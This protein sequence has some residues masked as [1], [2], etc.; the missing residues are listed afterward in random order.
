MFCTGQQCMMRLLFWLRRWSHIK[1]AGFYS[2]SARNLAD[3]PS[4]LRDF[5]FAQS[6]LGTARERYWLWHSSPFPFQDFFALA[7]FPWP[8]VTT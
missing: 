3:P 1:I 6:C 2:P 8:S 7:D 4:K 5:D